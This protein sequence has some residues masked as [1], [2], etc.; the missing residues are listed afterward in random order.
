L[1]A[2]IASAA[3]KVKRAWA[4][5]IAFGNATAPQWMIAR[6]IGRSRARVSSVDRSA[7]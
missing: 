6:S 4:K 3:S 5:P 7:G 1:H 2:A